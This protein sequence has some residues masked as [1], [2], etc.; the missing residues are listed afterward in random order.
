MVESHGLGDFYCNRHH[1]SKLDSTGWDYVSGLVAGAVLETWKRYPEKEAYYQSVKAFADFNLNEDGSMILNSKGES[2]LRPS[3]IDDLPAGRIYFTLYEEELR[4]GNTKDAERY[5]NAVNL[6]RNT[7]K[8]NHSRIEEGLPGAGGFFH[9]AVYPN[10]MWLDGLYMGSP[11]YAQWENTFGITDASEYKNSWDDIALQFVTIHQKTYN[12]DKQLNYHAWVATPTDSN[13]FWANQQDPFVGCS[14][15]FWARGM[16]WYFAALVDVLEFMPQDHSSYTEMVKIV[17]Q[18]AAGLK[19][20]QDDESGLWYQLLQY[21]ASKTADGQGDRINGEIYN[22]G[23][24][25]NYLESSASCIFT[26]AYLKGIRL[27]VLDKEPYLPVAEKAYQGILKNFLRESPDS[28]RIDIIQSCASAGLGPAKD[29]SRTGTIN[30]Y[31][32]GKDVTIVENE[33]KAIGTFILAS[34]EYEQLRY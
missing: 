8:Y 16:G 1:Q 7:L 21:D 26:Y 29:L 15:E 17:N 3:N 14:Q 12:A 4:K 28:E 24:A 2:A 23:D 10:Q 25:A 22:I 31:L 19:R 18:V 13:S 20:W 32:A 6:I 11:I 33:G 27:G 34:L 5:R 30:Y 9:K